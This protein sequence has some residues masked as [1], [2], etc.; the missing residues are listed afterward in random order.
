MK[1]LFLSVCMAASFLACSPEPEPAP[2]PKPP[3]PQQPKWPPSSPD[4]AV[5]YRHPEDFRIILTLDRSGQILSLLFWDNEQ[6]LTPGLFTIPELDQNPD[7]EMELTFKEEGFDPVAVGRINNDGHITFCKNFGE[8][9][10]FVETKDK[11]MNKLYI[12]IQHDNAETHAYNNTES[13][14]D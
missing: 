4:P 2:A 6:V 9:H 14:C 10:A 12:Y 5:N 13:S 7:D 1:K 3:A 11:C 8:C